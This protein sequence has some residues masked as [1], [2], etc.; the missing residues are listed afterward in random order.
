M[1]G[2]GNLGY[3]LVEYWDGKILTSDPTCSDDTDGHFPV[4]LSRPALVP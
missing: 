2:R 1:G 3:A 4:G